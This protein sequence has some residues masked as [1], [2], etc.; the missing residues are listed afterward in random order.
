MPG[1]DDTVPEKVSGRAEADGPV[2]EENVD[3]A[4]IS[5]NNNKCAVQPLISGSAVCHKQR[6]LLVVH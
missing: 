1:S 2:F 5:K 6:S 3:A 4:D